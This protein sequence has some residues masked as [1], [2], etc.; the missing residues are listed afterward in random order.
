MADRKVKPQ[1]LL[2]IDK[3]LTKKDLDSMKFICEYDEHLGAGELEG[4]DSVIKL[5]KKIGEQDATGGKGVDL[6]ATLLMDIGKE[7][8]HNKLLG[9]ENNENSYGGNQ[10]PLIDRKILMKVAENAAAEWKRLGR[11]LNLDESKL[12]IIDIEKN[13]VIDACYKVL[14]TWQEIE[15]PRATVQI[16]KEALH[17][18]HRRDIIHEIEKIEEKD[19]NGASSTL[20]VQV[21]NA[22]DDGSKSKFNINIQP[23]SNVMVGDGGRMTVFAGKSWSKADP[24]R[25]EELLAVAESV[26]ARNAEQTEGTDQCIWLY[27]QC[28]NYLIVSDSL[29]K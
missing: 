27:F 12:D 18:V 8:L 25:V 13:G 11:H 9:I 21:S 2:E 1:L 17:D 29:F 15:G 14:K 28:V 16:L 3:Y 22:R 20:P 5:F 26:K 10:Q 6:I 7:Q 24:G 23:G 4:V 19:K